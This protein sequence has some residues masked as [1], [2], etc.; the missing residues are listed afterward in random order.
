MPTFRDL[1]DLFVFDLDG[2]LADTR[3]DLATS[4]NHALS[5]LGLPPLSLEAVTRFVGD[6][7]R[8][9]IERALGSRATGSAV[10]RALEAFLDD[11]RETCVKTTS[12]YPGVRT[13]LESLKPKDLAVLTNKPL[14]PTR[15][16]LAA[17]GLE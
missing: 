4:L 3:Q 17:Q 8:V 13:T 11:Y 1:Y 9:L 2:T 6:G 7:A 10:E 12:L 15:R 5:L 16:I 14:Y